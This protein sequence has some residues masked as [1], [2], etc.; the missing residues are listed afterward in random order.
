MPVIESKDGNGAFRSGF[1]A[2]VGR[3]NVGKSTLMNSLLGRK[4]VIT[5]DKPQTTRNK[6]HCILNTADT[7][8]IFIDTPGIHKPK[9]KLGEIMVRAA[10]SSLDEVDCVVYMLD[11]SVDIG[12]GDRYI[13]DMLKDVETPVIPVLNKLDLIDDH[14]L[15]AKLAEVS[16][17][18]SFDEPVVI[19]AIRNRG[20]DLLIKRLTDL[21]PEG[22]KYYPDDMVTDHPERFLV[23][24]LIREK[25]L[26]LTRDEVPHSTAV[27]V[28]QM[29]ERKGKEMLYIGATI[30]VERDS[31]KGILIGKGGELLKSVGSSARREIEA[32]LG[33][34]VFLE[35]WVK[36]KKDWRESTV[37]LKNLGYDEED[38]E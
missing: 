17:L 22:P 31:Q 5:S 33:S 14:V 24:E 28:D 30:Y 27:A 11:A 37:A 38:H 29:V 18:G 6:I 23:S 16:G 2:V 15:N 4:V 12:A 1:V 3:P 7:Q 32:L 10:K 26:T 36:V 13:A 35:L 25:V 19:S 34:K 8:I 20:I 9:H 21:M